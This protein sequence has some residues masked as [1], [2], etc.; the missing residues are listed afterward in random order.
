MLWVS[1]VGPLWAATALPVAITLS[2]YLRLADTAAVADACTHA[3]W[4]EEVSRFLEEQA[5]PYRPTGQATT[6]V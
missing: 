5:A 3:S 2:R 4:I 6:T 1:I